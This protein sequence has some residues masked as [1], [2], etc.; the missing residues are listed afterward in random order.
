MKYTGAVQTASFTKNESVVEM[1]DSVISEMKRL[2]TEDVGNEELEGTKK[3]MTGLFPL[4]I[5]TNRK[6]AQQISDIDY[7]EL[8]ED[9]IY[10]YCRKL[11]EISPEDVRSAAEKFFSPEE[12]VITI[13]GDAGKI[14]GDIDN[15]GEVVRLDFNEIYEK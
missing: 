9:H 7:F 8:P 3:Y 1:V 15:Y 11:L 14:S 2:K 12:S 5:E 13:L 10:S 4:S 6:I